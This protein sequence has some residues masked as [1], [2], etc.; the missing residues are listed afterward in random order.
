M[1]R[2][3]HQYIQHPV[4]ALLAGSCLS[5]SCVHGRHAALWDLHFLTVPLNCVFSFPRKRAN[6]PSSKDEHSIGLKDSLL[7]H[8][9]DPVEMRRLNYQT[10]GRMLLAVPALAGVFRSSLPPPDTGLRGFRSRHS[11]KCSAPSQP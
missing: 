3:T 8:S 6:S 2:G 9:S 1:G 7:A 4:S 11:P 5:T 10:P